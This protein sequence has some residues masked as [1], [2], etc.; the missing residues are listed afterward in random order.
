MTTGCNGRATYPEALEIEVLPTAPAGWPGFT[1]VKKRGAD[2]A[3]PVTSTEPAGT[4]AWEAGVVP[5]AGNPAR[6][7]RRT[8]LPGLQ[9]VTTW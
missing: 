8:S 5:R 9:G 7:T 3:M 2:T 4:G 6:L 1:E